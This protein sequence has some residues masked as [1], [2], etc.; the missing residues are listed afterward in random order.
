M[1]FAGSPN[2]PS[3]PQ[4]AADAD[5]LIV[6]DGG[7]KVGHIFKSEREWIWVVDW[8]G[9]GLKLTKELQ[10]AGEEKS[11][12]VWFREYWE[13]VVRSGVES[14]GR[15]YARTRDEAIA[16]FKAVWKLVIQTAKNPTGAGSQ[17]RQSNGGAGLV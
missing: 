15:G 4:S 6:Y 17:V 3:L 2:A 11:A 7:R 13:G 10:T 12:E 5:Q 8:F 16:Q 14:H 1:T 9:V